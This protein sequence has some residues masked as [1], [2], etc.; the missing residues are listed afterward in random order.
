M[1]TLESLKA[2]LEAEKEGTAALQADLARLDAW[3]SHR[4]GVVMSKILE[5][6]SDTSVVSD[7][8]TE[9][10]I[11]QMRNELE[12]RK[13]AL[14]GKVRELYKSI[15]GEECEEIGLA[16]NILEDAY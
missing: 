6:G 16:W 3:V 15:K 4:R 14:V 2:A 13:E 7:K 8:A 12:A 11:R 10:G 9:I 5:D 1:L